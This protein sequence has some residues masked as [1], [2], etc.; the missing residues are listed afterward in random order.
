VREAVPQGRWQVLTRLGALGST[1]MQAAMTMAGATDA[2][3]FATF[4]VDVL[5]QLPQCF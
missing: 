4:V 3:V 1:G 5:A 2:D